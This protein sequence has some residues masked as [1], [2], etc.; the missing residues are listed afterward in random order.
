MD[1]LAGRAHGR[2]AGATLLDTSGPMGT[3]LA[4]ITVI[5]FLTIGPTGRMG[6]LLISNVTPSICFRLLGAIA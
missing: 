1:F 6:T 3:K 4:T 2:A 5:M